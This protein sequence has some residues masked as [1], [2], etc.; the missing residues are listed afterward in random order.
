MTKAGRIENFTELYERVV[1][2]NSFFSNLL[3]G[4]LAIEFLLRKIIVQ[5]DPNLLRFAD[6]LNHAR[7]ISLC[8]EIGCITSAQKS[9]LLSINTLRNKLAHQLTY[10]PSINELKSIWQGAAAAFSDMTDGIDQGLA[11]LRCAKTIDELEDWEVSELFVQ[12]S[13]DLHSIYQDNGGDDL[14]F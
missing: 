7:L 6:S 3:P 13:Y 8:F 4:H 14:E 12:I 5:Y 1:N 11:A 10:T 9:V 2:G